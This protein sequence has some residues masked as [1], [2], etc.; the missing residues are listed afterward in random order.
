MALVWAAILTALACNQEYD[1]EEREDF[2]S[3]AMECEEA[4]ARL[5]DCCP[6][7][8]LSKKD[9]DDEFSA[10]CIDFEYESQHTYGCDGDT[11]HIQ[12]H[13]R[14]SLS[15]DESNCIRSASCDDLRAR[16]VCDRARG[17]MPRGESSGKTL[18][19][20]LVCP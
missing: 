18:P 14:P 4:Y 13:L 2:T 7:F 8:G 3:E 15:R 16:R 20:A 9:S 1:R 19:H 17:L 5:V 11:D 10:L 12:G 6:G